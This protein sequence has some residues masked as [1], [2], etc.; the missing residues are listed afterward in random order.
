[1]REFL[2]KLAFFF[3]QR[4]HWERYKFPS[5]DNN[6]PEHYKLTDADIDRFVNLLKTCLE[7][8]MFCRMGAQDVCLAFSYLASLRPNLVVPQILDKL[9]LS[10]D[11]LT[12]PHKL[13]S[14]MVA[15]IAVGR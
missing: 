5:W 1:M 3:V 2:R 14:S 4:V 8:A 6:V 9:Y 12:E 13:T 7:P 11:S 10:M 15:I